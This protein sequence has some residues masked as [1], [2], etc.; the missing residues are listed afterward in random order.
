LKKFNNRDWTYN[1][2]SALN[3]ESLRVASLLAQLSKDNS[4]LTDVKEYVITAARNLLK[5]GV[6]EEGKVFYVLTSAVTQKN[7]WLCSESVNFYLLSVIQATGSQDLLSA[8]Q[9]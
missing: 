6:T 9:R 5:Q 8:D 7:S 2:A 1:G 4:D 3:I